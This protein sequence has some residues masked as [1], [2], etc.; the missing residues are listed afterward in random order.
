MHAQT[1]GKQPWPTAVVAAAVAAEC[2]VL[3]FVLPSHMRPIFVEIAFTGSTFVSVLLAVVHLCRTWTPDCRVSMRGVFFGM[4]LVGA[5][6][7][8]AVLLTGHPLVVP[9]LAFL[10]SPI[11]IFIG[12]IVYLRTGKSPYYRYFVAGWVFAFVTSVTLVAYSAEV[13]LFVGQFLRSLR[14]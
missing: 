2:L 5:V 12:G 4:L 3:Y 1:G 8:R 9:L 14:R 10:L 6:C 7:N 11:A 13:T